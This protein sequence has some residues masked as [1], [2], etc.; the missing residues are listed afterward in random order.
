MTKETS[1]FICGDTFT[2]S[3]LG[4][5]EKICLANITSNDVQYTREEN[6]NTVADNHYDICHLCGKLYSKDSMDIH[7]KQCEKTRAKQKD[8]GTSPQNKNRSRSLADL[9]EGRKMSCRRPSR[10][11][12]VLPTTPEHVAEG[13]RKKSHSPQLNNERVSLSPCL[14]RV[15]THRRKD[16]YSDEVRQKN[17]RGQKMNLDLNNTDVKALSGD[18]NALSGSLSGDVHSVSDGL[19]KCYM[20]R[21][22]YSVQSLPIHEKRCY[23][24]RKMSTQLT[25]R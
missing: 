10:I 14:E 13:A 12:R 7:V 4:E 1:C 9:S 15:A 11:P 6:N 22:L 21:Q 23:S 20:C 8:L 18:M 16:M 2:N 25:T 5:H 24:K 19:Q 17:L 3:A